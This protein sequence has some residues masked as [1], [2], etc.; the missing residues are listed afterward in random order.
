MQRKMVEEDL[1][2]LSSVFNHYF[3]FL[4][5]WGQGGGGSPNRAEDRYGLNYVL[6]KF[7]C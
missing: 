2:K 6:P 5:G 1:V 7:I 4:Q 3:L